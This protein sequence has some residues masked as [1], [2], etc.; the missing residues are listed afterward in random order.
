MEIVRPSLVSLIWLV[1]RDAGRALWTLRALAL[2]AYLISIAHSLARLILYSPGFAG[3]FG[4]ASRD[5]VA[6]MF[7]VGW[8]FLLVPFLIAVHRFILL[9]E[10]ATDYLVE[11]KNPR[12]LR[13]FGAWIVLSI[14]AAL[15][16]LLAASAVATGRLLESWLLWTIAPFVVLP[17]I[18]CLR[19]TLLLPA[20]AVDAPGATWV[21]AYHDTRGHSC[22]IFLIYLATAVPFMIGGA[23]LTVVARTVLTIGFSAMAAT[24]VPYEIESALGTLASLA[25]FNAIYVSSAV[26]FAAL[27]ARLFQL[28][29][30]RVKQLPGPQTA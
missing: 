11:T 16:I 14:V 26:L 8:I 2:T 22:G 23:L 6:L 24:A 29:G 27:A 10:A 20:I 7:G 25:V 21:N 19:M 17:I 1:Y 18:L 3:T 4:I 30:D 13:F 12:L 15:P 9:D 28:L 5:F